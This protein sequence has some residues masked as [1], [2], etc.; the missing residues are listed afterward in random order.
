MPVQLSREDIKAIAAEVAATILKSKA[1]SSA[2]V[3]NRGVRLFSVEQASIAFGKLE[4]TDSAPSP[5]TL[6]KW[7]R[8]GTEF[9]PT[10]HIKSG[11][12]PLIDFNAYAARKIAEKKTTRRVNQR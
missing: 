9:L 6:I 8:E 5:K 1:D 7:C 3:D 12:W 2:F 4:E 10:E 11:R